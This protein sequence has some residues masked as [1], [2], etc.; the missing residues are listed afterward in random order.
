MEASCRGSGGGGRCRSDG[1]H[2]GPHYSQ[3]YR[4]LPVSCCQWTGVVP[5]TWCQWDWGARRAAG[6]D[7]DSSASSRVYFLPEFSYCCS[8]ASSS[9]T[10]DILVP[11]CPFYAPPS[12]FSSCEFLSVARLHCS[13][14]FDRSSALSSRIGAL[15]VAALRR[16]RR[17]SPPEFLRPAPPR[18]SSFLSVHVRRVRVPCMCISQPPRL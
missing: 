13:V 7:G 15:G 4:Y 5:V 9:G 8:S 14:L 12:F 2:H 18:V 16:R 10:C 3:S 6:G 11:P 1:G 17:A